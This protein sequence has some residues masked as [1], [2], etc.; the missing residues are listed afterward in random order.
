MEERPI[1]FLKAPIPPEEVSQVR[2]MLVPHQ[3]TLS[4][5]DS[6][7]NWWTILLPFGTVKIVTPGRR[8]CKIRLPDNFSFLFDPGTF[9]QNGTYQHNPRIYLTREQEEEVKD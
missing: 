1:L 2:A 7:D 5:L 3:A 9:N 6:N 4:R 8:I